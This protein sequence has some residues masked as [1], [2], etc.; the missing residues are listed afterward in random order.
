[1]PYAPGIQDISGQL[2]AQGMSQAGAAR[3]RA[4][5]KLGES[6]SGGIKQYQQNQMFTQQALGKFGQQLQDPTFKQYVDRVVND[7][8][9]APQVPDALK[10]AFK[11][12]AAG[13]VDIYDAALLGTAT[14]GYQQNRLRQAQVEGMVTE[15][16]LR[17]AQEI[18]LQMEVDRMREE[19]EFFKRLETGMPAGQPLGQSVPQPAA[20]PPQIPY[21]LRKDVS[22]G[23]TQAIQAVASQGSSVAPTPTQP[24]RPSA[25]VTSDDIL[26]AK[27]SAGPGASM[28]QVL[29]T[30]RANAAARAKEAPREGLYETQS[31]AEQDAKRLDA[32][33]PISGYIRTSSYDP[34]A[35]AFVIKPVERKK[36]SQEELEGATAL[37]LA[38]L[39]AE[40]ASKKIATISQQ[41]TNARDDISRLD[42]IESAVLS[43]VRTGFG[44][45]FVNSLTSAAVEVGLYPAGK[46]AAKEVLQ[47]DVSRDALN[48]TK[49]FMAGQGSVSNEERKRVD[50]V[51][52]NANMQGDALLELVR[53][54]RA[55]Y[56]RQIAADDYRME[57]EDKYEKDP[58]ARLKI[59][60]DMDRWWAKNTIGKFEQQLMKQQTE[61]TGSAKAGTIEWNYDPK[62]G[63]YNPTS[64]P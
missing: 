39:E 22:G 41:A 50:R 28:A 40:Q 62:T 15:N 37:E 33:S 45:E 20:V 60:K 36:T 58:R 19:N 63:Q 17:K 8:P 30:A 29:M 18:K 48:K 24:P 59:A 43:G 52:Q 54:Q 47:A 27:M 64:K 34:Q 55:V 9:N 32:E 46:Q 12:A 16:A 61:E 38:K 14:E 57:L 35:K 5:E 53:I 4:I 25:A 23:P 44:S 13:K 51:A 10:K 21:F 26:Q 56:N 7:D 42:R 6:I 31:L 11:N 3:A 1:M 49:E 2:L